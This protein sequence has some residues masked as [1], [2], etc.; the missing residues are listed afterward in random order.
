MPIRSRR[1]CKVCGPRRLSRNRVA[2]GQ[3]AFLEIVNVRFFV[4]FARFG[5]FVQRLVAPSYHAW[6]N[7]YETPYVGGTSDASSTPKPAARASSNV[8]KTAPFSSHSTAPSTTSRD[9]RANSSNGT[10]H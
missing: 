6:V 9:Q 3:T 8:E 10:R 4:V 7:S 2:G 5:C 1:S